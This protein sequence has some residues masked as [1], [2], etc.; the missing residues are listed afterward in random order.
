M[1]S[2]DLNALAG[3]R[4]IDLVSGCRACGA[5]QPQPPRSTISS[6]G[7]TVFVDQSTEDLGP[8]E[9]SLAVGP[10]VDVCDGRKLL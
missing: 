2:S 4:V 7:V 9:N 5:Q 3:V 8:L 6:S 1:A 10:D